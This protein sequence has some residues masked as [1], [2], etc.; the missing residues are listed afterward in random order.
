MTQGHDEKRLNLLR[1]LESRVVSGSAYVLRT[2]DIITHKEI[3]VSLLVKDDTFSYLCDCMKG[4][5]NQDFIEFETWC[6]YGSF[7]TARLRNDWFGGLL[8]YHYTRSFLMDG[9]V[10]IFGNDEIAEFEKLE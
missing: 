10:Y 7:A 5:N 2:I 8:E 1:E 9:R 3:G 6:Q 4:V